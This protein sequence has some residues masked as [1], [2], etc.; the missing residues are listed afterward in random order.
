[1]K[2][3]LYIILPPVIDDPWVWAILQEDAVIQSG[4]ACNADDKATLSDLQVGTVIAVL[5][6]Q[7]VRVFAHD[8]PPARLNERLRAAAYSIEDRLGA[9]VDIQHVVLG[10]DKDARIMVVDRHYLEATLTALEGDGLSPEHIVADFD[11]FAPGDRVFGAFERIIVPGPLGYTLDP[12]W[13]NEL[14]PSM[15]MKPLDDQAA[16]ASMAAYLLKY[17]PL[18]LRQ[19]SFAKHKIGGDTWMTY[20]RMVMLVLAF[21]LTLLLWH[22]AHAYALSKMAAKAKD[23]AANLYVAA[24][25]KPAPPNPALSLTQLTRA[26]P[27]ASAPFLRLSQILFDAVAEVEGMAVEQIQYDHEGEPALKLRLSYPAFE[28]ASTFEAAIVRH[29]GRLQSGGIREAGDGLSGDATLFG[30]K[31]SAR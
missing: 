1:M 11:T 4:R 16:F 29:G 3:R 5:P 22:G 6:G 30:I 28:T 27:G 26:S 14:S 19:G 20:A 13:A 10:S 15:Q 31:E 21:G 24:M 17:V 9:P 23:D 18:D 12:D 8:L 2:R 25:G 7:Y